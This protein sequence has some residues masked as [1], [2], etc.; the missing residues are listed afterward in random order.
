MT[1]IWLWCNMDL[2]I[3]SNILFLETNMWKKIRE[4]YW[5]PSSIS[6]F[7]PLLLASFAWKSRDLPVVK[8]CAWLVAHKK[9]EH[10]FSTDKTFQIPLVFRV[11]V[12][13]VVVALRS[14]VSSLPYG[15]ED[16][17]MDFLE[18][19]QWIGLC[20]KALKEWY[21]LTCIWYFRVAILLRRKTS[22]TFLPTCVDDDVF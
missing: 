9:T 19:P 16:Y 12:W 7:V 20:L 11:F 13:G 5:T 4:P 14:L 10:L 15:L 21:V 6:G 2:Y 3:R 17:G 1:I 18:Y 22:T 8:A